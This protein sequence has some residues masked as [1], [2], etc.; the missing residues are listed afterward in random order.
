MTTRKDKK[1]MLL[2]MTTRKHKKKRT[3]SKTTVK[4]RMR[5]LEP[6][7]WHKMMHTTVMILSQKEP[8]SRSK[9]STRTLVMQGAMTAMPT[10]RS[11]TEKASQR[12]LW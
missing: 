11:K 8:M 9:R 12:T 6:L 1:K 2:K 4:K 3:S 7:K 5:T 10:T